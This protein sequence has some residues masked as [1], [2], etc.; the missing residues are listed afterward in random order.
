M[1]CRIEVQY[2]SLTG[3]LLVP[4]TFITQEQSLML[5]LLRV[6]GKVERVKCDLP[7]PTAQPEVP[8]IVLYISAT[9]SLSANAL[10]ATHYN[11]RT[12]RLL[13][14]L[15][16]AAAPTC[17]TCSPELFMPGGKPEPPATL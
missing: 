8:Q 1:P 17:L 12:R 9:E 4:Q 15:S 6:A 16:K 3:G 2:L 7:I 10:S 11:K 14:K 5:C 13:T